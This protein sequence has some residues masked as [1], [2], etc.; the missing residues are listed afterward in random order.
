LCPGAANPREVWRVRSA[1]Q[2]EGAALLHYKDGWTAL[3][4]WDRSIDKR[5][6]CN[7]NFFAQGT[8]T[9]EEMLEIARAH[10]PAVMARFTFKI[11]PAEEVKSP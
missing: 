6:G 9:F 1:E 7:S 5:S 10:F 11:V 3:S 8:H 4:F 2:I